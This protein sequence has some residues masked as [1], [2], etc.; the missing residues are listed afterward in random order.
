MRRREF[1]AGLG[2]MAAAWPVVARAQQ[3]DRVGRIGV[4]IG[5]DESD[6]TFKRKL[7]GIFGISH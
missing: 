7:P 3:G 1:I 5:G 2:G 6:P 4:L